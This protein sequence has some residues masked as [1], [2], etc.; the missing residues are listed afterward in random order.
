MVTLVATVGT[1][2]MDLYAGKLAENLDVPKLYTDIYQRVAELFNISF[3]NPKAIRAVGR[4]WQFIRTLNQQDNILHLPNQHLG[5]YGLFLRVPYIITVHDLIRYFDYKGYS[6]FIHRPNLRD[7][8]YLSLDYRGIKKAVRIIAVSHSTKRDLIQHLGI[9][10]ERISVVYEGIDHRLFKPTSRRL[11]D[12]P[13]I[14]FVGSEHPRKNL[15]GLLRAF[16]ILKSEGSFPGLKLVKVGKAGGPEA[17]FR[18]H[19]R[20]LIDGLNIA[21]DVIF[22]DY[23][24]E[25]DL[26]A[27]YSGAEC[28]VLP[29]H[30]EG[31]G[32]P[33]LEAMACGCPVI[34]SNAASLP[35]ITGEAALKVEPQ[36]SNAL[37]EAIYRVLRDKRLRQ[38]LISRGFEQAKQF[39]WER[40]AR[41]TLAVYRSVEGSLGTAYVPAEVVTS[42]VAVPQTSPPMKAVILVGGEGTRLRPLTYYVPKPMVPLVNRPFLEHTLAY[43]KRH[44][45]DRVVLTLSYLPEVIQDYFGD[46]SRWGIQ[47]AY[48]LEDNPLGTAGAV[49]NAEGYLDGTFVVLN[50]DIFTDIN[51]GDM[52][53]FHRRTGARVSLALTWVDNPCAF[54]VVETDSDGRVRRFVEKPSPEQVTSHWINAGVY[55][56]EPEVLRYVPRGGHCMFERELFPDLLQLG[57]PVYGY[58]ISNYWLDMGTPEKYLQL[59]HDL[60]RS[61]VTSTLGEDWAEAGTCSRRDASIHATA[62]IVGPVVIGGGGYIGPGAHIQGPVV[63]G[64]NCYIGEGASIEASVLWDGVT[65]GGGARIKRCIVASR[66]RIAGKERVV[67]R[68][69]T[70]EHNLPLMVGGVS[71]VGV[72]GGYPVSSRSSSAGEK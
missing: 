68:V 66:A 4:D 70:A 2:S 37:A 7:K 50:G 28:F 31:F 32:F 11:V 23:I 57:E 21:G 39:S 36:D 53:A 18:K 19:S 62:E 25:A 59:N 65:V 9:P 8:F 3:F 51:L 61:R 44:G 14:L 17:E 38:E 69:I 71:P 29:S 58:P 30:Y 20:Q 22:T 13:Y 54:G 10:E 60:L 16:A 35:E 5:R 42:R 48:C 49:K 24:A 72:L 56:V 43:L 33:P 15:G 55:I 1:G 67:S 27:Y 34:V 52:I 46:G 63:I 45:I 6:T 41:E 12:Y 47:L 40:T 26:P 64:P